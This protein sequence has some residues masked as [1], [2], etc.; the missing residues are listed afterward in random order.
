MSRAIVANREDAIKSL[1]SIIKQLENGAFRVGDAKVEI[2]EEF[3]LSVK[4]RRGEHQGLE[5][6]LAWDI[7][8]E[9]EIIEEDKHDRIWHNVLH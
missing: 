3:L 8:E 9:E 4:F 1:R 6:R 5:I 2:P 7:I